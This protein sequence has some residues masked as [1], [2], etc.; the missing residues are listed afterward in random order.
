VWL[1]HSSPCP[2]QICCMSQSSLTRRLTMSVFLN[3]RRITESQNHRMFGV[4][5]DL[6]GSPS[7]TPCPSRVTQSRLHRTLSRWVLDISREGD[8]TASLGSLFQCSITLRMK[9]FF[10]MFRWKSLSPQLWGYAYRPPHFRGNWVKAGA[11]LLKMHVLSMSLY[12][13]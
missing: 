1:G 7:P 12:L 9:K 3:T 5:R 2:A 4:G 11:N 8:S 13:L 10:L 6:C